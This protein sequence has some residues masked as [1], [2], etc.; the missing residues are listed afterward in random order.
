[1]KKYGFPLYAAGYIIVIIAVIGFIFNPIVSLHIY[2]PYIF[3]IGATFSIIGRLLTLPQSDN[4]RVRRLNNMLAV[5]AV[6]VLISAYLIFFKNTDV[7]GYIGWDQIIY[8]FLW[9]FSNYLIREN[10]EHS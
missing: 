2:I 10:F 5:S 4:F 8:L 1:M 3:S 7:S 6:L 9:H